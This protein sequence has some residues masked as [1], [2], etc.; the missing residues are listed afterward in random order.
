MTPKQICST[1]DCH[2]TVLGLTA[3]SGNPV[4][5]VVIFASDKSNGVVANWTEGIDI[6]V[7]PVKDESREIILS[8]INFGEGKYFPS[9][10]TCNF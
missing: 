4:L 10:P 1:R 8:E 9:G 2:F 3:S 5:C 7:D 6:M